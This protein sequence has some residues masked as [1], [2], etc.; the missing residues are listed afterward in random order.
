M[1][2][3]TSTLM[4]MFFIIL[5][6]ISFWKIYAFLP[7]EKLS[8]DDTTE[9]SYKELL[10]LMI[11]IIKDNDG[12][13]SSD[14]LFDKMKNSDSFDNEHFWRFNKNRL[15]HLLASYYIKHPHTKSIEDIY[16]NA[17]D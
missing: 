7:N 14:E 15:N 5:F 10:N 11:K 3:E 17:S 4:M 2:F 1:N 8:D 16:K 12:K 9:E 13:I 6:G